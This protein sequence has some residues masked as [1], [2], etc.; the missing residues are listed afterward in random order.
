MECVLNEPDKPPSVVCT[1]FD[2]NEYVWI[3]PEEMFQSRAAVG[4]AVRE[5]SF[6]E[7][8]ERVVRRVREINRQGRF[9]GPPLVGKETL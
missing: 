9:V 6:G 8:K 3:Y 1:L 2:R 5:K 7:G 4:I